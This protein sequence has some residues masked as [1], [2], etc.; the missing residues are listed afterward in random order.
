MSRPTLNHYIAHGGWW[1]SHRWPSKRTGISHIVELRSWEFSGR[2]S[3]AMFSIW[4]RRMRFSLCQK[5]LQVNFQSRSISPVLCLVDLFGP[6]GWRMKR[7]T[8]SFASFYK[9]PEKFDETPLFLDWA[10]RHQHGAFRKRSRNLRNFRFSVHGG[11]FRKRWRHDH[12]VISILNLSSNKA[13]QNNR[14]LFR[15]PRT[16]I[17]YTDHMSQRV[18]RHR[19]T[20]THLI[21]IWRIELRSIAIKV[22]ALQ[23]VEN[24]DRNGLCEVFQSAYRT[25]HSRETALIRVYNDFA[26]SI[27]SRKSV[28][29]VLL[30]FST[31]SII[32]SCSQG[33]QPVLASVTMQRIG[34]VHIYPT[35]HN[36]S[37]S[38]MFLL[39]WITYGMEFL[40]VPYWVLCYIHCIHPNWVTLQD[41]MACVII[42]MRMI[43]SYIC[44]LKRN[45][46]RICQFWRLR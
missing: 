16:L 14:W 46:L 27:D 33:Y 15:F 41:L 12:H 3:S 34:F 42:F 45:R 4:R 9:K 23:L 20:Y 7:E 29:L 21:A 40:E 19:Q 43:R 32:F 2:M 28:V 22:V 26:L 31:L 5:N 18:Q 37:E 38:K 11:I 6:A 24:I 36:L 25:N 17:T 10:I 44:P 39:W 8:E 35:V 1:C 30:D 13:P